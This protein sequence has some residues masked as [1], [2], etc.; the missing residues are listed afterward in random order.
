MPKYSITFLILFSMC[1]QGLAQN[2]LIHHYSFN[3]CTGGDNAGGQH[4]FLFG[5]AGCPCGVNGDA[6]EL[7]GPGQFADFPRAINDVLSSDFTFSFY[8]WPRSSVT[9]SEA[10]DIW[11]IGAS[12]NRDTIFYIRYFPING[13]IRVRISDQPRNGIDLTGFLPEGNCWSYL[14]VTRQDLEYKLYIESQEVDNAF[15]SIP[16][17]FQSSDVLTVSIS[18]CIDMPGVV[19]Y[20]G[21]VDELR[22]Y[23]KALTSAE[24]DLGNFYP[25]QIIEDKIV[26]FKGENALIETGGTCAPDFM[27]SPVD[28]LQDINT[29]NPLAFPQQST[30]YTLDIN[31]EDCQISD[32][33]DIIVVDVEELDCSQLLLPSAFT[34]NGDGLND[35]FGISNEFILDE[36]LSFEI[37]DKW[38]GRLFFRTPNNEKWDGSFRGNPVMPGTYVY[39]VKYVCGGDELI[40]N[41]G[42]NVIR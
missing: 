40:I 12:C 18:P 24:L 20:E 13:E 9:G 32:Q 27:W 3:G 19:E 10:I 23:N 7:T 14:A 29:L 22:I 5:V 26:I 25:D 41:G 1:I 33:I 11:S 35:E 4:G 2:G 30:T 39:R 8:M 31:H 6:L 17:N 21:L 36:L 37:F 34:P 16:T 28:D 15:S 38:G 42:V